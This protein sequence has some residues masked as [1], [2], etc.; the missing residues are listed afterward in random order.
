MYFN[1]GDWL[2]QF[3]GDLDFDFPGESSFY[4]TDQTGKRVNHTLDELNFMWKS[5]VPD[6]V[7]TTIQTYMCAVMFAFP[8]AA[9]AVENIW[10]VEGERHYFSS[11]YVS[12]LH[13]SVEYLIENG[14]R[15]K[16][17][18]DPEMVLKWVFSQNGMV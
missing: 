1:T 6:L 9:R 12:S 14:I 7:D 11:Y 13:N 4:C 3:S 17:D 5:I 16:N 10:L 15:L 8:T 2:L 18:L